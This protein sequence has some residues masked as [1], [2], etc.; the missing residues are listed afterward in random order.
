MES[1]FLDFTAEYFQV[2]SDRISLRT[3]LE[4][5]SRDFH[6][7]INFSFEVEKRY[8]IEF[9]GEDLDKVHSI[10]DFITLIKKKVRNT[11]GD[12]SKAA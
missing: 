7:H 1:D 2:S 3:R 11:T 9:E 5:L 8:G 6:D 10:R 4:T 12:Y